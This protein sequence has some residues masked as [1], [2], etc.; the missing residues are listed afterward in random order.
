[1]EIASP[2]NPIGAPG[3]SLQGFIDAIMEMW[4]DWAATQ[5]IEPPA[6]TAPTEGVAALGAPPPVADAT[7]QLPPIVP[8]ENPAPTSQETE[9]AMQQNMFW[10]ANDPSQYGIQQVPDEAL[11]PPDMM[12]PPQ[13][14]VDNAATMTPESSPLMAAAGTALSGL[15]TPTA[16]QYNLPGAPGIPGTNSVNATLMQLL[17]AAG[18][19]APQ[20]GTGMSLGQRIR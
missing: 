2:I 10:D 16:P 7:P 5:G 17:Q 9:A 11:F 15:K 3:G 1:M 8:M 18:L 4:P 6:D 14:D 19:Q 12:M 20:T 13:S